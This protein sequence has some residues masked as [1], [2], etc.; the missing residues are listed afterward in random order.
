MRWCIARAACKK[1][2]S[3]SKNTAKNTAKIQNRYDQVEGYKIH[4]D[5]KMDALRKEGRF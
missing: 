4:D 1:N 3:E 5:S 2:R